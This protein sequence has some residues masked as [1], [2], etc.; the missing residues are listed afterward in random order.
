MTKK[1]LLA[2]S[3]S[4]LMG[5]VPAAAQTTPYGGYTGTE[6]LT[7]YGT[8]MMESYDVAVRL[9]VDENDQ[10]LVGSQITGVRIPFPDDIDHLIEAQAWISKS[11]ELTDY[12]FTPDVE[13][14]SFTPGPGFIDVTFDSPY[15]ITSEGVYVGYSFEMDEKVSKPIT[16]ISG[17]NPD[18]FYLHTTRSYYEG[19]SSV[20]ADRNM[21]L[22]MQVLIDGLPARSVSPTLNDQYFKV[23]EGSNTLT[24]NIR[25]QGS[26]PVSSI[27]VAY[28]APGESDNHV[29]K[30]ITLDKALPA[31]YNA[32]ATVTLTADALP[33]AGDF[34]F[35]IQVTKVDSEGNQNALPSAS[36]TIHS[37]SFVPTKR[38]LLEEYTGT[39]CGWCPKGFVGLENM[40]ALL[41]DD[42]VGVSYHNRDPMEFAGGD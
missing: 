28:N 36:T 41:G 4:L 39:W 38:A 6:P 13:V 25:N 11:L 23:G 22:A 8:R 20:S 40:D 18:Y 10:G 37:L 34:P 35:T 5:A 24:F 31:H 14:K 17:T 29:E 9:T 21:M 2:L 16:T 27:D 30:H 12:S 3:A 32:S 26:L 33:H 15:T 19:F 42:F 7:S 1:T